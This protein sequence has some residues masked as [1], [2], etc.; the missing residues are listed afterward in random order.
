MDYKYT[1]SGLDNVI[2]KIDDRELLVDEGGEQVIRIP[3]INILHHYIAQGI[4]CAPGT[5]T[6]REVKFLRTEMGLTQGQLG[7]LLHRDGQ[8]IGRWERD[9]S[10]LEPMLDMAIRQLVTEKLGLE[11]PAFEKLS[12]LVT[13]DTGPRRI[14]IEK[15][16]DKPEYRLAG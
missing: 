11:I 13:P 4:V 14:R 2:L 16:P 1:E 12:E 8:S 6:G 10:P 3:A 9:E 5:L 15:T 7:R